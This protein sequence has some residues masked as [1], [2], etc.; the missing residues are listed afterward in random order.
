MDEANEYE[1]PDC[2][3]EHLN[4]WVA[5]GIMVSVPI[6]TDAQKEAAKKVSQGIRDAD[7]FIIIES[8]SRVTL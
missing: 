4:V 1:G 5:G 8:E 2:M 6:K 3:T 7:V